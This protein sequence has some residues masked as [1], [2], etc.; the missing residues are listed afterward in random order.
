M[1]EKFLI[2]MC[3]KVLFMEKI[4]VQTKTMKGSYV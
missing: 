1:C 4:C 2:L 3:G